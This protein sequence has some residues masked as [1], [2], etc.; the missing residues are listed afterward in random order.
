MLRN[1]LQN[2]HDAFCQLSG[3]KRYDSPGHRAKHLTY[4][5]MD[6]R[7]NKIVAFTLIQV[8]ET[9]N[10]K[11]M[12]KMEFQKSL[13]LLKNEGVIPKLTKLIRITK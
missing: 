1:L 5:F 13:T 3:D 7:T 4:S 10:S 11:H 2:V 9:N 6:K 8:F 12:E